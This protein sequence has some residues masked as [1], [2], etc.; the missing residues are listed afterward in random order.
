MNVDDPPTAGRAVKH[1]RTACDFVRSADMEGNDDDVSEVL[2]EEAIGLNGRRQPGRSPARRREDSP[3][4][5]LDRRSAVAPLRR[6]GA[7]EHH[8]AVVPSFP[9][10]CAPA[11]S[12]AC[13]HNSDWRDLDGDAAFPRFELL[14][15][16][17]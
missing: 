13:R 9:N 15:A 8:D 12:G 3:K 4:R 16:G 10:L 14:E 6:G 17:T 2:S 7:V 11:A 5:L 1:H